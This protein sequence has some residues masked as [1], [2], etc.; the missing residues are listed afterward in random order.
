M[1]YKTQLK[2]NIDTILDIF[3]GADGGV[4]FARFNGAVHHIAQWLDDGTL[5]V[6]QTEKALRVFSIIADFRRVLDLASKND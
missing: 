1:T 3:A 2:D 5:P 4:G 6:E